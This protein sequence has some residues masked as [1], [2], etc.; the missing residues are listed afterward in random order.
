MPSPLNIAVVGVGTMA[1]AVHLPL[2]RRRWDRFALT[3]IVEISPRRRKEASEVWGV[4]EERRY[5]SVADLVT[6][7]RAKEIEVDAV[8]VASDGLHVDDVLAVIRRG[9][10]VLVEPPLG[11]S[12]E[13]I[14]QVADFERMTGRHLV[15]M[16]YPQQYDEAIATLAERLPRRDIRLLEHEVRM[17]SA[18]PL[19]GRAH[20]TVSAYDLPSDAR[21]QRREALQ[22]A[23]ETGTGTGATQRDRDLYVKG[24]LTGVAHQLA[25]LERAYGPLETIEAVR[26]WPHGVIP[27]SVELLGRFEGSV[28]VRIVWHY[29]PFFPEY[30][31]EL[32]I[33][34]A[35]R[36]LRI[37]L[38]APSYADGRSTLSVRERDSGAVQEKT[39]EAAV[40]AAESMWEAFHAFV[41]SGE[42]PAA[43]SAD[44][45]RRVTQLRDVLEQ[46]VQGDGRTLEPEAEPEPE[47]EAEPEAEVKV[48]GATDESAG[49][50][51]LTDDGGPA[52]VLVPEDGSATPS[53]TSAADGETETVSASGAGTVTEGEGDP[54]AASPAPAAVDETAAAP[55]SPDAPNPVA[56]PAAALVSPDAPEPVAEPA[57]V[58]T[59]TDAP[60]PV[61]ERAPVESPDPADAIAETDAWEA[62]AVRSEDAEPGA[63]RAEHDPRS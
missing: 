61:A 16:A 7:I 46:I 18:Q 41:V 31:E 57:A 1:Q 43:G 4:P 20:V 40:G 35:R 17:P 51:D 25:A 34:S 60:D 63:G 36:R 62:S 53:G 10:P 28:P 58:S 39:V 9:V 13:E 45:L 8:V 38:P 24:L 47:P 5:E 56:E 50:A 29:L 21:T 30:H 48:D 6:A 12:A 54:V 37:S 59:R 33:L 52:I 14:A 23:V 55:A 15:M 26:Q 49:D 19:F 32:T 22:G 42:A 2:I 27:G 11:F 44:E 3:G